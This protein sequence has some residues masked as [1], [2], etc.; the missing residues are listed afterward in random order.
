M[1]NLPTRDMQPEEPVRKAHVYQPDT[2]ALGPV[3]EHGDWHVYLMVLRRRLWPMI[4]VF[5]AVLMVGVVYGL[6]RVPMYQAK[7]RLLIDRDRSN[8]AGLGDPLAQDSDLDFQTQLTILESRSLVRRTMQALGAWTPSPAQPRAG[9]AGP[10]Q[11]PPVT[12]VAETALID[13]FL[14]AVRVA[15]IP[16]SRLVDVYFTAGDP[17][18]AAKSANTLA[19]QFIVQNLERRTNTSKEVTDWLGDRLVDQ[20]KTLEAS[21]KALQAYRE[22]HGAIATN[23]STGFYVQ[24]LGDLIAAYTK[25]KT[26]RIEKGTLYMQAKAL[27]SDPA[28]LETFPPVL[29][30]PFVQQLKAELSARQKEQAQLGERLGARHPAMIKAREAVQAAQLRLQAETAKV[31][32]S[33]HQDYVAAEEGEARLNQALDAQKQ[34]SLALNRADVQFA[35]L[36]HDAQSNRQIYDSLN[37]RVNEFAVTRQRRGSN[38]SV[39]DPAEVPQRPIG[40]NIWADIR[41]AALGGLVLALCLAFGLEHFDNRVKTPSQIQKLGLAL[42]ALVPRLEPGADGHRRGIR[43]PQIDATAADDGAPGSQSNSENGFVRV[44]PGHHT[45]AVFDEA[46]RALRTNL[47]LS[48]IAEGAQTILVTSPGSGDGKSLVASSLAVTLAMGEDRVIL[49]DG[50]LRR[51]TLHKKFGMTQV[52]GLAERLT[53]QIPTADV[54]RRTDYP[55]LSL[56]LSGAHPPNPSELLDSRRFKDLLSEFQRDYD[57][58]IIDSPPVMPVTDAIIISSAAAAVIVVASAES[59]PLPAL[60]GAVEQL[61]RTHTRILGAVLNRTDFRRRGYYYADYYHRDYARYYTSPSGS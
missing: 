40:P 38:I 13:G 9:A 39:V 8:L 14:G 41:Y 48:K 31:V 34:E 27:Q 52:P 59:T 3:R 61:R 23:E 37:Q 5:V 33:I 1:H 28:S 24:K 56:L 18:V 57:W 17:A 44:L 19:D 46:L 45:S 51:P 7:V 20:R 47:R 36:Q 11:A 49:I 29:S 60:R 21:E 10:A 2:L 53:G 25:A 4:S 6:N 32:E 16:D 50:D 54:V 58:I 26:E 35:V 55:H 12:T 30:S 43:R 15:P 42:L 22:Q